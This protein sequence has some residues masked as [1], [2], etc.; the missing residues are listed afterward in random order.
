MVIIGCKRI[1]PDADW[2][3]E[4]TSLM[5]ERYYIGVT[6][7]LVSG[8][9]MAACVC[10]LINMKR[11]VDFRDVLRHRLVGVDVLLTVVRK[12]CRTYSLGPLD[13]AVRSRVSDRVVTGV[14]RGTSSGRCSQYS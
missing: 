10:T 6:V 11:G 7:R 14:E 8:G 3:P 2:P 1:K 4:L 12:E 13:P 9:A 5:I